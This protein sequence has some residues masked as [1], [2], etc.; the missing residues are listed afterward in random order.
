[1][2]EISL[3]IKELRE[4]RQEIQETNEKILY[5]EKILSEYLNRPIDDFSEGQ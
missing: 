3:Y 1:M 4:L 5:L 2:S